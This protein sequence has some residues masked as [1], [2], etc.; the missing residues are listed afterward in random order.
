MNTTQYMMIYS[1]R[2]CFHQG[3]ARNRWHTQKLTEVCL[4]MGLSKTVGITKEKTVRK[5]Q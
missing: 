3:V 4:M 2:E 1:P 5:A